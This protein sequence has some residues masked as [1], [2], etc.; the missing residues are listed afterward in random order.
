MRERD[1]KADSRADIETEKMSNSVL[2]Q[3]RR[4]RQRQKK[5]DRD[6]DS[7]SVEFR[8]RTIRP[9][10]RPFAKSLNGNQLNWCVRHR[11]RMHT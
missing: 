2:G 7:K 10:N 8:A 9:Q 11:E 4:Q 6:R 3:R 1:I 5:R